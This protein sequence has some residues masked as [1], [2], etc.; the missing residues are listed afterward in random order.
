M[1]KPEST[2]KE[3]IEDPPQEALDELQQQSGILYRAAT[4]LVAWTVFCGALALLTG[5]LV[6]I[7]L[8]LYRGIIWLW[9]WGKVA[10][11]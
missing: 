7:G 1:E 10:A 11:Q 4:K 2:P 9:P 3:I 6:F 5:T 8:A